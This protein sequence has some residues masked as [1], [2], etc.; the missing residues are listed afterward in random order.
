MIK[1][2]NLHLL[3]LLTRLLFLAVIAKALSLLLWW[4][5]PSDGEELNNIQNYQPKYQ[6]VDF[7]NMLEQ[8]KKRAS[9]KNHTKVVVSGQNGINI[10]NMILKG[11]YGNSTKGFAIV[12]LK[13]HPKKTSIVAVGEL[14]SGY[15]LKSIALKSVIFMKNNKEYVLDLTE[16]KKVQ[17]SITRVNHSREEAIEEESDEPRAVSRSDINYFAK[18]PKDIW[19]NI[20][21]VAFRRNGVLK[22]F[23]ITRINPNSKFA[24]LGLKRGDIITKANNIKLKSYRDAIDLYNNINKIQTMQ[25]VVLRNNQ[26]REFV[27]EIN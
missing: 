3:S 8:E 5:L 24:T 7:R 10:T 12:A 2:S 16:V 27:Y 23:K 20:S 17:G 13:S 14:F 15:R 26:E 21:I 1:L 4:Y 11:L 18:N 6:R 19:R 22:G 25:I 9:S